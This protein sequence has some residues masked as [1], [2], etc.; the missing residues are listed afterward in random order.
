MIT[1]SGRDNFGLWAEVDISGVPYRMRWIRPGSFLMG[2]PES[3]EGRFKDEGPQHEVWIT[4]GF[5]IGEAPVTQAH[6]LAA[7]KTNPAFF[8]GEPNSPELRRPV[9][10]VNWY[11]CCDFASSF[12]LRL[13][14]EA[15]WEYSCRAG[16]TDPRWDMTRPLKDLAWHI[17][18]SGQ[19]T[20]PV[21]Q[22]LPNPWGLYDMLGNVNEWCS[23]APD[24]KQEYL[25]PYRQ[26]NVRVVR[27]GSWVGFGRNLRAAYRDW[28]DPGKAPAEVGFRLVLGM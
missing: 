27:G 16:T 21:G 17:K 2:S 13:P 15:E 19:Q 9:E 22:K 4:K 20:H 14:T 12:G 1:K 24:V 23:D 8:K 5:W 28:F 3:E 7:K 10:R 11:D 18:N 6:W 26:S 25:L